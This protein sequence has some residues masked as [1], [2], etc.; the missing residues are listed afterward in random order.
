MNKMS[1]EDKE[2]L[3]DLRDAVRLDIRSLRR[4]SGPKAEDRDELIR[5]LK[6][7][8]YKVGRAV[9]ASYNHP[10]DVTEINR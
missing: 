2:A 5:S 1:W 10:M 4:D 7:R 9:V 6:R 3:A 8:G